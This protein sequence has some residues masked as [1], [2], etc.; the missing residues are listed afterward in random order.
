MILIYSFHCVP[1]NTNI[2]KIIMYNIIMQMNCIHL[3]K[4][5]RNIYTSQINCILRRVNYFH[6]PVIF[7]SNSCHNIMRCAHLKLF[8]PK[9]FQNEFVVL[10]N[11]FHIYSLY[12]LKESMLRYGNNFLLDGFS[13]L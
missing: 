13:Y 11:L 4:D 5:A 3:I 12:L 10:Q 2:S 7:E 1:S 6:F 9:W 8:I